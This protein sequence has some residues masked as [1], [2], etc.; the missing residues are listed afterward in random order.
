M[1]Q[2]RETFHPSSP[3]SEGGADSYNHE[4]TPDTRLT[5]FSPLEDSSKSSGLLSALSLS[6]GKTN[7]HP[8]KFQVPA[9]ITQI[10]SPNSFSPE[11][12]DKDPFIS[13][14]PEKSQK[15]LSATASTFQPLAASV[16]STPVVAYGSSS[17]TPKPLARSFAVETRCPKTGIKLASGLSH[18]LDLTRSL[19]ISSP[20]G[21]LT[22]DAVK[23]Y[24]EKIEGNGHPFRQRPQ[25]LVTHMRGVYIRA[26]NI[27]DAARIL[28]GSEDTPK[29]W[30]VECVSAEEINKACVADIATKHEGQYVILVFHSDALSESQVEEN[31][32]AHFRHFDIFALER[33]PAFSTGTLRWVLEFDEADLNWMASFMKQGWIHIGGSFWVFMM[34]YASCSDNIHG[35]DGFNQ[36]LLPMIPNAGVFDVTAGLGNM[37]MADSDQPMPPLH[38]FSAPQITTTLPF[39]G[40]GH[41]SPWH[42]VPWSFSHHASQL[43]SMPYQSVISQGPST[44]APS[45]S[46][47]TTMSSISPNMSMMTPSSS[48][49]SPSSM[50]SF[51]HEGSGPR[52]DQT[53]YRFDGRRQNAT[54]INRGFFSPPGPHH[55]HVDIEKI[56][57]G[58]DVRTTIMLRNIPNKVD[59]QMLKGI[60]DES[61]WGK[62]DF[63]YL[64][65]DFANDCNVGYAFINFVDPLDI[66]DFANARGNQRWNCFKSDKVAEISYATIQGKDCLVQ[67]F[68]NSSVMLEAPHYRPKL[69]YTVNG[70]APEMAGHEEPFPEPDNQSKMKRSCENAEHVG[71]FTPNAGQHFRDEQRRRRSQYD[72][73]TRLAALEECSEFDMYPQELVH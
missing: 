46:S 31:V 69:Y 52:P 33:Q 65:I 47:F 49:Q 71:L 25:V 9:G 28:D 55:N 23:Q 63:M 45:N 38:P 17:A 3:P 56:K 4:G 1:A 34:P 64:R 19:R 61:S 40:Q 2:P 10:T 8:I 58:T 13:S 50:I 72:R 51:Y 22:I 43:P 41:D 6:G 48:Q 29:D 68:R 44:P 57:N 12:Q 42:M 70:P 15:K 32:L 62:Y 7:V 67:K 26:T 37:S 60:I 11:G 5:T 39:G 35:T 27:R 73:G 14:T 54:R 66:I 30:K 53:L 59:Q 20:S 21:P 24:L 18:N 16:A 36:F